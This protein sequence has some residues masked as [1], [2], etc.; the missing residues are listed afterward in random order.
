MRIMLASN[1]PSSQSSFLILRESYLFRTYHSLTLS[2]LFHPSLCWQYLHAVFCDKVCNFLDQNYYTNA[3]IKGKVLF[4]HLK[5]PFFHSSFLPASLSTSLSL[6]PIFWSLSASIP[7]TG[8]LSSV[9][10]ASKHSPDPSPS[11]PK[12]YSHSCLPSAAEENGLQ[13]GQPPFQ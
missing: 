5:Y 2:V 8:Q 13:Q 10:D 12:L 3:K 11:G 6:F 7:F 1:C 9:T 4:Y